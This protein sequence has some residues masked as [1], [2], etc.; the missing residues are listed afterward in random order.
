MNPST[1]IL[2]MLQNTYI[3]LNVKAQ[4]QLHLPPVVTLLSFSMHYIFH[5]K[6]EINIDYFRKKY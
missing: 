3:F 4:L 5:I 2:N 6:R 1:S